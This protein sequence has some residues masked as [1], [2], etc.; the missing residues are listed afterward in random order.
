MT[1]TMSLEINLAIDRVVLI[2][3]KLILN[4]LGCS[5]LKILTNFLK[6]FNTNIGSLIFFFLE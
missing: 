5:I 2:K 4:L 6:Y 1:T 3:K